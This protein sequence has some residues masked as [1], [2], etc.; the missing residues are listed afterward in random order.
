[1]LSKHF[2]HLVNNHLEKLTVEVS[3]KS[4]KLN[5]NLLPGYILFT[6]PQSVFHGLIS[7]LSFKL[8]LDFRIVCAIQR[9][10][11]LLRLC[12]VGNR[13]MN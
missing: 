5:R 1:M 8:P 7:F 11:Q 12:G 6:S 13:W 10:C 2:A 9:R 4:R 3:E